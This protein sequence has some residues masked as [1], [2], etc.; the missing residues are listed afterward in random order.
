MWNT[1][2][3]NKG[4]SRSDMN[5]E[6]NA[7]EHCCLPH[8]HFHF[9]GLWQKSLKR[10]CWKPCRAD[11]WCYWKRLLFKI[12]KTSSPC[13]LLFHPFLVKVPL[14][15]DNVKYYFHI[16]L[17]QV[18][19]KLKNATGIWRRWDQIFIQRDFKELFF[20][21]LWLVM[22]WWEGILFGALSEYSC[23]GPVWPWE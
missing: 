23:V 19:I 13:M 7:I 4:I 22:F 6:D 5:S 10:K 1:K 16:Y 18:C 8:F 21:L 9:E 20:N 15:H 17:T 11:F 14:R 3:E 2:T 12:L